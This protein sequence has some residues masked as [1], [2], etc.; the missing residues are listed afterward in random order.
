MGH[1]LV[2][3]RIA[4]LWRKNSC[5]SIF[6]GSSRKGLESPVWNMKEKIMKSIFHENRESV[7]CP[8]SNRQPTE[9][10]KGS[11]H[12]ICALEKN[13]PVEM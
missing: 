11:R 6:S 3:S 7:L 13:S 1:E 8:S 9:I 4:S 5:S 2:V 10:L 12:G